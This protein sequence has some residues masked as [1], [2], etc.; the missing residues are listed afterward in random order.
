[1]NDWR[2]PLGAVLVAL[3]AICAVL[4]ASVLGAAGASAQSEVTIAQIQAERVPEGLFVTACLAGVR[5]V[6]GQELVPAT[7]EIRVDQRVVAIENDAV[8]WDGA[9]GPALAS[10]PG[11]VWVSHLLTLDELTGAG[12]RAPSYNDWPQFALGID[13]EVTGGPN[14]GEVH[15]GTRL[16]RFSGGSVNA[17]ISES[18]MTP[19]GF[20]VRGFAVDPNV[21]G[22][23]RIRL[24]ADSNDLMSENL[25]PTSWSQLEE[26]YTDLDSDD[27]RDIEAGLAESRYFEA[28]VPY[29]TICVW[30]QSTGPQADLLSTSVRHWGCA[31]AP[32]DGRRTARITSSSAVANGQSRSQTVSIH[33]AATDPWVSPGEAGPLF[34]A[35]VESNGASAV[36]RGVA[37]A[38]VIGPYGDWS[39]GFSLSI[40]LPQVPSGLQSICVYDIATTAPDWWDRWYDPSYAPPLDCVSVSVARTHPRPPLGNVESIAAS[41]DVVTAIGWALDEDGGVP[42][43]LMSANGMPVAVTVPTRERPDVAAIYGGDGRAG[44]TASV[45]LPKGNHRICVQFEDTENGRWTAPVC[46]QIVIK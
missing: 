14:S 3:V 13:V 46:Q 33:V 5:R 40:T 36:G 41:G 32:T 31:N 30:T 34:L 10:C 11:D 35:R 27:P 16:S 1:M 38:N 9:A 6:A 8:A 26:V 15:R 24:T 17:S 18:R 7:T 45:A 25:F 37:D 44:Y 22:P 43:V 12:V 39:G 42:R 23:T 21:G 29:R 2:R 28:I 20:W 4:G 19:E